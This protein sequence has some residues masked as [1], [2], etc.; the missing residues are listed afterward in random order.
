MFSWMQN[1][2]I[3]DQN[4]IEVFYSNSVFF[5]RT[6]GWIQVQFIPLELLGRHSHTFFKSSI[7]KS[8]YKQTGP[9]HIGP[10]HPS[11]SFSHHRAI[12]RTITNWQ[13][14]R[15]PYCRKNWTWFEFF[16][17]YT[18]LSQWLS[19]VMSFSWVIWHIW[20]ARSFKR[21]SIKM[22]LKAALKMH[23]EKGIN[24]NG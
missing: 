22:G 14:V 1:C 2:W 3:A 7:V 24:L 18:A 10:I 21:G 17:L 4:W 6:Y 5:L 9:A 23:N 11:P 19:R 12:I 16:E 13:S 8:W 20:R 15:I